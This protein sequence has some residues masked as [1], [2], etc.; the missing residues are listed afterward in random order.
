MRKSKMQ[1]GVIEVNTQQSLVERLHAL[2][3]LR[4]GELNGE[5]DQRYIEDLDISIKD[6]ERKIK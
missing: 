6:C 1:N 3:A 5:N 2:K 4:E